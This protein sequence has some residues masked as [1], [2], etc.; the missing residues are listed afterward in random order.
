MRG[1]NTQLNTNTVEENFIKEFIGTIGVKAYRF[2][3]GGKI[4][5]RKCDEV[6]H[7]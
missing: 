4:Y 2:F 5:D 1:H 6:T 7:E 3:I